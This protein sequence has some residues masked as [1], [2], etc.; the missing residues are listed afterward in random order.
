MARNYALV[1]IVGS[2]SIE[3]NVNMKL[4][5]DFY[6][7]KNPKEMLSAVTTRRSEVPK[8]GAHGVRG[9][10]S[11]YG[12]RFLQ[13]DGEVHATSVEARVEMEQDLVKAIS[14]ATDQ[15]YADEDGYRQLLIEDEDGNSKQI[16]AK[17]VDLEMSPLVDGRGYISR[18]RFSMVAEDDVFLYDQDLST[19][20]GPESV[21]STD[22]TIQD[23]ALPSFLDG[24]LPT[25]QDA[26]SSILTVNNAGTQATAPLIIIRG[27]TESPV[28][29]N[30]TTGKTMDFSNSGGLTL[31]EDERIEI[32]VATMTIT[33]FDDEENESD[34]SAYLTPSSNRIF[35]A[36]GDNEIT[37]FDDSPGELEAELEVQFRNAWLT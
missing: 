2:P 31:L 20:E 21:L 9:S 26:N 1:T 37:I 14:L 15:S 33:K 24:E 4:G 8:Q 18:F 22:F 13:F 5:S 35:L 27:P 17:L 28:I 23:G 25:I 7:L 12:P 29:T 19:E 32:E 36:P 3:M 16:Y 30:T 10:L 34:A 11:Q 6:L